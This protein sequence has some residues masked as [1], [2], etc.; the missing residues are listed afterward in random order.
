M[1]MKVQ[2]TVNAKDNDFSLQFIR[3]MGVE[4]VS[5]YLQ[6]DE[7]EYDTV[8]RIQER[9]RKFDIKISDAACL[10]M[11]KNKSI[12]LGLNN[13]DEEIEKFSHMIQVFGKAE[14]P[15][16]SIAW[17]PN[18]ILRTAFT[19]HEKARGGITQIADM[20]E[21]DARPLVNG[22]VYEEEEI[23]DN[24]SYFL[25]RIIPVCEENSVR[26]ALHPNDPPVP[27]LAGVHSLIY[28]TACFK[29]AFALANSP[30]LG[31]K[32][33]IGCWLEAGESFGNLMQDIEQFTREERIL[34]IH[35]RNVSSTLPFFIETLAEDGYGDMY[36]IMKKLVH[37][38]SGAVIS[39]DH[40]FEGNPETGGRLASSA[41]PTGYLKGLLHAAEA[42]EQKN[43]F[44]RKNGIFDNLL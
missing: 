39:I 22:K 12:H 40:S 41:Y 7:L 43:K 8:K 32:L 27:S 5:L 35:F 6:P 36:S 20:K 3:E 28:N 18:G 37:C 44:S 29:R 1:P 30:A 16:T 38:N 2:T 11:Q 21:I 15:F 14:I 4:Y 24:F 34:S 31:M 23:W 17:Q 33:C 42:E 9:F 25:K 19:S 13:R 26:L 10:Q